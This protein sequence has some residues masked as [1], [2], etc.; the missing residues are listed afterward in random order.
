MI[1]KQTVALTL[2]VKSSMAIASSALALLH[3]QSVL[4][5]AP[6]PGPSSATGSDASSLNVTLGVVLAVVAVAFLTGIAV[7]TRNR[8]AV[9]QP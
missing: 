8:R 7:V 6:S 3:A 9:L 5:S 2:V 4:G 1:R